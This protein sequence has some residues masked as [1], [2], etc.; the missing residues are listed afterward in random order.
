MWSFFYYVNQWITYP[1]INKLLLI[2]F[3]YF[4]LC[5]IAPVFAILYDPAKSIRLNLPVFHEKFYK[6]F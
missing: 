4:S 2:F 3:A 6:S 5:P 1:S